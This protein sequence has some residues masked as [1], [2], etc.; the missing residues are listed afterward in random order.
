MPFDAAFDD[1]YEDAIKPACEAA[2]AYAERVD[3]QIFQS[4]ILQRLY[5]QIAKADLIVADT[6]GRNVNVLYEIGYAHALRKDVILVTRGN[7]DVVFDPTHHLHIVYERLGD[8]RRELER[9]VRNVLETMEQRTAPIAIPVSVMVDD[10]VLDPAIARDVTVTTRDADSDWFGFHVIVQN[11]ALRVI[12]P[13]DLQVGMIAPPQ[14]NVSI[15]MEKA[16]TGEMRLRP[17]A[18]LYILR[19]DFALLPGA[20]TKLWVT[21]HPKRKYE[22]GEAAGSFAVRVL[23]AEAYYDFAFNVKIVRP[24][25]KEGTA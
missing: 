16:Q 3:D 2:G 20:G 21:C 6:T 13:L 8:L 15:R 1:V 9:K 14:M 11:P 4:N 25:P 5:N 24:A 23:T 18:T 22:D 10:V 17:D 12:R 19:T 7:S